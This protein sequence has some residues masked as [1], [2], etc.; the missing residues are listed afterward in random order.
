MERN[1][2]IDSIR[3]QIEMAFNKF[4]KRVLGRSR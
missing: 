2:L 3:E 4:K 1:N